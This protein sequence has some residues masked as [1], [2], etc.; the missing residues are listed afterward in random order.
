MG[1]IVCNVLFEKQIVSPLM[2]SAAV[3]MCIVTTI[4]PTPI[5]R[6]A[7][8]KYGARLTQGDKVDAPVAITAPT[9]PAMPTLA[10]LEF[11]GERDPILVTKPTAVIGRHTSDD[12]RIEDVRVSRSHALLTVEKD[13]RARLKNQTADRA[14]PNPVT[15][16]GIYQEDTEIKDGDKIGVGGFGFTYREALDAAARRTSPV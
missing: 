15:V 1:L 9:A 4:L 3:L 5:L 6:P 16:N 14:E 12:I 7:E 13:G 11:E 8:R 10:R 2:F